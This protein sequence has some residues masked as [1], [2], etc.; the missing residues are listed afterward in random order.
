MSAVGGKRVNVAEA[1]SFYYQDQG[2]LGGV[3]FW[4]KN[5]IAVGVSYQGALKAFQHRANK[6]EST[7]YA[8]LSVASTAVVVRD[9]LRSSQKPKEMLD[10]QTFQTVAHDLQGLKCRYPQ[11]AKQLE[12][13]IKLAETVAED[14]AILEANSLKENEL[15]ALNAKITQ[16]MKVYLGALPTIFELFAKESEELKAQVASLTEQV[17]DLTQENQKLNEKV[18]SLDSRL[19]ELERIV[20]GSAMNKQLAKPRMEEDNRRLDAENHKLKDEIEE[21]YQKMRAKELAAQKNVEEN[22][23]DQGF[24][25][26]MTARLAALEVKTPAMT[27]ASALHQS[28]LGDN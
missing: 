6:I 5:I 8:L 1:W 17:S 4:A 24:T 11:Y 22:A 27:T 23:S 14:L 2:F 16:N 15:Q 13:T 21:L 3:C 25:S 28:S 26:Q 7:K 9:I 10:S 19:A 18:N 20:Q 12:P